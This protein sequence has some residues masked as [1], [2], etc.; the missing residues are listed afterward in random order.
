[1]INFKNEKW[2]IKGELTP[3][4]LLLITDYIQ[5]DSKP[6]K[7]RT[8]TFAGFYAVYLGLV[9]D[10]GIK[11]SDKYGFLE[12][13]KELPLKEMKGLKETAENFRNSIESLA[14]EKDNKNDNRGDKN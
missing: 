6:A 4:D 14:D 2:G 1:M 11:L 8:D 7:E 12:F 9:N 10:L 5:D 13:L 3:Y